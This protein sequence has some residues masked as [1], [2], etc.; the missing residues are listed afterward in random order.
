MC[1]TDDSLDVTVALN[2]LSIMTDFQRLSNHD[3]YI[4]F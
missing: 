1:A 2:L 3:Y 4:V